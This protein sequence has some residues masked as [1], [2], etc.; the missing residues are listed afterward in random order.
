[1]ALKAADLADKS[2]V[3]NE[4]QHAYSAQTRNYQLKDLKPNQGTTWR[5]PPD[6][7]LNKALS[8]DAFSVTI[9]SVS[10]HAYYQVNIIAKD[11]DKQNQ[12]ITYSVGSLGY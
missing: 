11:K 1:M 2:K 4:I 6:T 5:A 12:V 10:G 7:F 8:K 3:F 9:D